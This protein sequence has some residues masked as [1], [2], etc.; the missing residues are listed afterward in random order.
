MLT[1]EIWEADRSLSPFLFH[2][3]KTQLNILKNILKNNKK[4][5]LKMDKINTD[6]VHVLTFYLCL[7]V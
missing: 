4:H 3:S 7:Y 1:N 2:L 5:T 6:V